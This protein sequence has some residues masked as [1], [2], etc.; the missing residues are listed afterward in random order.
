M[1]VADS[2]LT[3]QL[4]C[5]QP[6]MNVTLDTLHLVFSAFGLVQKIATFEKGQGFQALVQYADAETAEQVKCTLANSVWTCHWRIPL[7]AYVNSAPGCSLCCCI[8]CRSADVDSIC[9][10]KMCH[11]AV[12]KWHTALHSPFAKQSRLH[13][14][15]RN[16][17]RHMRAGAA[18]AGRAPHPQA[19][20]ERHAQPTL[21]QDHLLPTHRPQRQVPVPPI[22][23][24]FYCNTFVS[25]VVNGRPYWFIRILE[26]RVRPLKLAISRLQYAKL[27]SGLA[28]GRLCGQKNS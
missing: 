25:D 1:Q 2:L 10:N 24:C 5:M 17:W 27:R 11:G 22:Q 4:L 3:H 9:S 13:A 21:P 20:A 15:A 14:H 6:D 7:L 28:I 16:M 12:N 23:V 18:G 19:P 8:S 26:C